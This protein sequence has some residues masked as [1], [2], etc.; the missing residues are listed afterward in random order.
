MFEKF[1]QGTGRDR[2]LADFE[3]HHDHVGGPLLPL[4]AQ[5]RLNGHGLDRSHAV[6]GFNGHGPS[7]GDRPIQ[8]LQTLPKRLDQQSDYQGDQSGDGQNDS[9]QLDAVEKEEG[10]KNEEGGGFQHGQEER[11]R[12][13]FPDT[14]RLLHMHG[15]NTSLH[16]LEKIEGQVEH[17]V[18][19][20]CGDAQIYF[21]GGDQQEVIPQEIQ[22]RIHEEGDDHA[23]AE[24]LQGG[25]G[26]IDQHL[27]DDD[28]KK[29][30]SD[31]SDQMDKDNSKAN[32]EK[33]YLL[34]QKFG[35]EPA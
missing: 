27:V 30:W 3:L 34:A 12:E 14:G 26:L 11:A 32:V 29:E 23:D 16:T 17:V 22:R 15:Y 18:E 24:N 5:Q 7:L 9:G 13:K 33:S 21:V 2:N 20:L 28:L 35:N 6:D 4:F 25:E 1:R 31:Q 19:S 10:Q 8:S